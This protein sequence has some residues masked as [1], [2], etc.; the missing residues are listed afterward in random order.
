IMKD[1]SAPA[2][3]RAR[4]AE[5]MSHLGKTE[6]TQFLIAAL[7]SP[8]ADLCAAAVEMLGNWKSKIDLTQPAIAEQ[9]IKLLSSPEPEVVKKAGRLC[10]WHTVPGAEEGLRA[11]I[12][13]EE[14]PLEE[15]AETLA[16]LATKPE[17][18]L[19]ALPYLFQKRQKEYTSRIDYYFRDVIE[20][21]N[22]AV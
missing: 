17:S 16:R 7:N 4:A 12:A 2:K 6:G 8:S 5:V 3:G 19:A 18:I 15:L 11:A 10:G 1:E 22:P 13:K 9:I 21:R 14:G 20:H